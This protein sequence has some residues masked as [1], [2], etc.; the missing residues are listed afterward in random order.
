MRWRAQA[1]H[2]GPGRYGA[3]SG[4]PVELL[5]ISHA[6]AEGGRI[7]REWHLIDDVALWMQVLQPRRRA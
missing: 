4:R 5:A 1:L 7:V 3:P 6:E 2:E